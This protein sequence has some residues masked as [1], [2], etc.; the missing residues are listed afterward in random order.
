MM[1]FTGIILFL[2]HLVLFCW[3]VGGFLETILPE[4]FW[5]PFTN[6]AFP[7]WLLILHW[8]S[9]LFASAVFI[10]GY[11][12]HWRKTP[13]LMTAGYIFMSIVCVIETFGYMTS[14]TKYIAMA[15]ELL[16]YIIILLLLYRTT[17]FLKY[18]GKQPLTNIEKM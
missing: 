1:K 6:T 18:F 14:D 2:I 11:S 13:M 9:I 4:V 5:K 17:Y 8:S 12:T 10:Y 16:A 3:S 15:T 7:D